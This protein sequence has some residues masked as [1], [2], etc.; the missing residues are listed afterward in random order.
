VTIRVV[1][2][3]DQALVRSGLAMILDT[4]PDISV[5]AQAHDGATALHEARSHRPDIVLM[6]IRMPLVDGLTATKAIT[7]DPTLAQT[8]IVILTTYD[9]D[10]YLFS[11]LRAGAAGFLLKGVT[12]EG[13][14]RAVR[15]IAAGGCL[16]S[17][18]P[19]RRLIAEFVGTPPK[20]SYD[21]EAQR[22]IDT[23]T[24]RE[25]EVLALMAGGLTNGEI[26]TTLVIGEN[27]TK[28]HVGHIL[29][30]L[31]ARDRVQAVIIAYQAGVAGRG[32]S[33]RAQR[34]DAD[35]PW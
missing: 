14:I 15:E 26:A 23:L 2:A 29:D 25:T 16:L 7:A 8:K 21:I 3:D 13:L 22:R 9:L 34:Q 18:D 11:A 5:V 33:M 31:H 17:P 4:Q 30:K 32:V 20:P 35:S 27:T 28:T 24:P 12:P 19:T 1:I 6:D 10:E